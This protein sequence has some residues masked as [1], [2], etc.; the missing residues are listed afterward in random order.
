MNMQ[1][2]ANKNNSVFSFSVS[3]WIYKEDDR[4][5]QRSAYTAAWN[6]EGFFQ[7]SQML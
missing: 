7:G 1:H 4:S 5:T 6:G 2:L 3:Q